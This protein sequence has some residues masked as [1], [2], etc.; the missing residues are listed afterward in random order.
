M[1]P[2]GVHTRG[3]SVASPDV[4]DAARAPRGVTPRSF[5]LGDARARSFASLVAVVSTRAN[6]RATRDRD[7]KGVKKRSTVP[8]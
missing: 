8:S 7:E 5:A 1:Y 6:A 4:V 2:G 3:L